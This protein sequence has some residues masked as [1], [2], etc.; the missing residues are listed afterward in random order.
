M[1]RTITFV[2]ENVCSIYLCTILFFVF[3]LASVEKA[4]KAAENDNYTSTDDQCM[5]KGQRKKKPIHINHSDTDENEERNNYKKNRRFSSKNKLK[6]YGRKKVNVPINKEQSEDDLM[7]N[8]QNIDKALPAWPTDLEIQSFQ[9]NANIGV[10]PVTNNNEN[11]GKFVFFCILILKHTRVFLNLD[12][13]GADNW[14]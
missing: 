8:K 11:D 4:R 1:V 14:M 10:K 12:F 7:E 5:G 2:Y 9:N 13:S 3:F 6:V